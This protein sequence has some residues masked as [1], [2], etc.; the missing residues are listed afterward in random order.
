MYWT[1]PRIYN[2]QNLNVVV[3]SDNNKK[4]ID[5]IL[6]SIGPWESKNINKKQTHKQK[7]HKNQKK[8]NKQNKTKQKHVW[9]FFLLLANTMETELFYC[10]KMILKREILVVVVVSQTKKKCISALCFFCIN[11]QCNRQY[12][13]SYKGQSI[14][15]FTVKHNI[16][17]LT[18]I[19]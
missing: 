12:P 8:T 1:K 2:V 17:V 11:S 14:Q 4:S 9:F 18:C 19:Y 6:L 3:E 13:V 5:A 15:N 10:W 7:Q 16:K